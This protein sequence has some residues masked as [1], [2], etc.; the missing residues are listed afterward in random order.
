MLFFSPLLWLREYYA[1]TGHW[2]LD[3][4]DRAQKKIGQ[5][6]NQVAKIYK[7]KRQGNTLCLLH[8]FGIY[9]HLQLIYVPEV[10]AQCCLNINNPMTQELKNLVS[11]WIKMCLGRGRQE[12]D[13]ATRAGTIPL[14]DSHLCFARY[15]VISISPVVRTA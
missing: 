1:S 15:Q 7:N 10:L 13:T 2:I 14:Q 11:R 4:G 12:G 8:P 6:Q 9:L 5:K 3:D